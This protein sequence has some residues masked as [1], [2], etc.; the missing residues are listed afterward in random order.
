MPQNALVLGP[1]GHV[2]PDPIV[3]AKPAQSVY[4]AIQSDPSQE[5]VKPESSHLAPR[6]SVI[7]EQGFSEAVAT[8]I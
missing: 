2:E 3:P 4:S 8:Q 1:S 5:S 6:T 7:E